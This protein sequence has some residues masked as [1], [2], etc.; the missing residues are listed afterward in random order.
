MLGEGRGSNT[1]SSDGR[2]EHAH[3]H[4]VFR[5]PRGRLLFLPHIRAAIVAASRGRLLDVGTG[6]GYKL[7]R[8]LEWCGGPVTEAVALEPSPLVAAARSEL[9]SFPQ[10][11][12]E[13]CR[14]EDFQA[15][16]PFDTILM[17]EVIEHMPPCQHDGV[18]RGLA[19]MLASDGALVLTTPNRPIY[20]T[21]VRLGLRQGDPT[22]VGELSFRQLDSLLR[23]HFER[24]RYYG[25]LLGS[26]Q[27]IGI[28]PSLGPL[29][30]AANP[31]WLSPSLMAVLRNPVES[32]N[33]SAARGQ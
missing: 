32:A 25:Y 23:S 11:R 9:A 24:I 12:V 22:H 15:E 16:Q 8:I 18:L 7:G 10:A 2:P 3:Y 6:A 27:L 13:N 20:R 29:N 14:L 33:Q 28:L 30:A 19:G 1:L 26:K 21:A 4:E 5:S 31:T 17:L